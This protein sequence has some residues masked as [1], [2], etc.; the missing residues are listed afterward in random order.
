MW[1]IMNVNKRDMYSCILLKMN[2]H[3]KYQFVYA[4]PPAGGSELI[5]TG[6]F[7]DGVVSDNQFAE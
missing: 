7:R 1:G 5:V 2:I 3:T 6:P 4:Y